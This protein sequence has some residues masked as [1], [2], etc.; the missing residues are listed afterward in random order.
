VLN[1]ELFLIHTYQ[2][3]HISA[4]LWHSS[5]PLIQRL[6]NWFSLFITNRTFVDPVFIILALFSPLY[7]LVPCLRTKKIDQQI[8]LFWLL[9]YMSAWIGVLTS[10]V[11]R[12]AVCTILL[13]ILI[14]LF[15]WMYSLPP[16]KTDAYKWIVNGTLVLFSLHYL[17]GGYTKLEKNGHPVAR[18][19]L[20]P[21][22]DKQYR[23]EGI[24]PD[25]PF[26]VLRPGVKLYIADSCHNCINAGLPCMVYPY[27]EIEMRGARIDQG[28]RMIRDTITFPPHFR[29]L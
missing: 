25:F 5:I 28:F 10:M 22:K 21:L 9:V 17:A 2:I 11:F 19:W 18:Y 3:Q 16:R 12:F 14:P 1:R 4:P 6:E 23:E 20:L 15:V 26:R 13:S 24:E 7:W 29:P 27:G 8:F